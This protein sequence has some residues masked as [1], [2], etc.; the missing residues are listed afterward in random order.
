MKL[1]QFS[2]VTFAVQLA[3]VSRRTFE[4][5]AQVFLHKWLS[6]EIFRCVIGFKRVNVMC[7]I[8][9]CYI[10]TTNKLHCQAALQHPSNNITS[11]IIQT[12][13]YFPK[14][15]FM[16]SN[17]N[18]GGRPPTKTFFIG[19]RPPRARAFFGSIFLSFS[20]WV[21]SANTWQRQGSIDDA[22]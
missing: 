19:S 7:H 14:Y 4:V 17:G 5:L 16:S 10:Q 20:M 18:S 6:Q 12:F 22:F 15:S 13:P 1:R 8:N 2:P 11:W 21:G 3:C 9:W